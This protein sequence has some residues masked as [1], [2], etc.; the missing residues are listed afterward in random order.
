MGARN[1]FPVYWAGVSVP[2]RVT[3]EVRMALLPNVPFPRL[4]G[5][6]LFPRLLAA[7]IPGGGILASQLRPFATSV[8]A[9]TYRRFLEGVLFLRFTD[10]RE[11][12]F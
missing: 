9:S 6:S 8:P 10:G 2:A 3:D 12:P 4:F 5:E 11:F 1:V 7:R